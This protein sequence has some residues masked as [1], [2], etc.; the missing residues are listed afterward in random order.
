[1]N[2]IPE[3]KPSNMDERIR[4]ALPAGKRPH[5]SYADWDFQNVDWTLDPAIYKAAPPSLR[6]TTLTLALA[7]HA[8]TGALSDGRLITWARSGSLVSLIIVM[9]RA[10][11]ADGG[12]GLINTYYIRIRET[13]VTLSKFVATA[14]SE[15]DA[16]N[17]TWNWL[18]DT[19]YRIR[20]TW[21]TSVDRI[22][23]RVE[24]WDGDSWETLGGD[25]DTDLE[26]TNDLW[27]DNARN[28]CGIYCIDDRWYDDVE[29]WGV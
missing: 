25:A 6:S 28:R 11:D 15:V 3:F 17:I 8:T 26:D 18:V 20:V 29:I 7:K 10:Q 22:Y 16:Q 9:F 24:Y 14:Q 27:K 19:W 21:W 13:E 1:M 5:F 2:E 12:A 4:R 23:V